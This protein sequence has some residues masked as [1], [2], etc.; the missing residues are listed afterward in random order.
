MTRLALPC[1]R[2]M[3]PMLWM[4]M[5]V[6]MPISA[7][8]WCCSSRAAASLVGLRDHV[9]LGFDQDVEFV[10]VAAPRDFQQVVRRE[11]RHLEDLF[12]DLRRE[13]ID[14]ADDQHVVGAA[15]DLADAAEGCA[16]SAAAGGSGRACGSG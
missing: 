11:L 10:H 14:A 1:E 5:R 16:L 2:S 4:W 9:G 6:L 8:M 12:L 7:L 13:D 15:G 3:L